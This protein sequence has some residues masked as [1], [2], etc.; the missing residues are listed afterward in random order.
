MTKQE[1][2]D[3]MVPHFIS[4]ALWSSTHTTE[5]GDTIEG[6]EDYDFSEDATQ[7]A[8]SACSY[9]VHTAWPWLIPNDGTTCP[10]C[11]AGHNLW[12]DSQGHGAGFEDRDY[13]QYN[14]VLASMACKVV[15]GD[16]C[17]G[18]DGLIYL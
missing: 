11:D 5:E 15:T 3:R 14:S 10:P 9:F 17:L 4:C 8:A 1:Y 2:I 13:I 12:L 18:D 7:R 16:V 6:L